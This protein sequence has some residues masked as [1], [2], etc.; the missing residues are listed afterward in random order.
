MKATKSQ[1][2]KF[3]TNDGKDIIRFWLEEDGFKLQRISQRPDGDGFDFHQI[4]TKPFHE[5]LPFCEGQAVM[6]I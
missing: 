3:S 2:G 6:P 4:I 1:D 5:V